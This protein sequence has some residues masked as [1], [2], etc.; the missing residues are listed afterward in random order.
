MREAAATQSTRSD[1]SA[2]AGAAAEGAAG[3]GCAGAGASDGEG[4]RA[5]L[6][7]RCSTTGLFDGPSLP[8]LFLAAALPP[9][10]AMR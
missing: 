10:V 6:C 3:A 9:L 1:F 2:V 7:A 5:G 8:V 4:A